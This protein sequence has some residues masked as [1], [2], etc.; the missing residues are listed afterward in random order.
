M[1]SSGRQDGRGRARGGREAQQVPD[2]DF[3]SYYGRP[4]VRETVWGP[5]I[6]SYL[7]LG[8]LAGASSGLAAAAHLTGNRELALAAKAAAAG[9]ISLSMAALVHDLGR[10]ARFINML[11]VLKVTSP[12]SVGTWIVSGYAPLAFAAAACN[13]TQR[14]RTAGTLA[15]IG[16]AALG[17][18]VASYTAVLLSDT[19]TPAWHGAYRELPYLFAGSAASAA[20]GLGMLAVRPD[21]ARQ[22][23]RL[24]AVG[25]TA[26][27]AARHLLERR[28]GKNA[29]PYRTGRAGILLKAA[30]G[31]TVAG[32]AGTVLAGTVLAGQRR[33]AAACSGAALLVA[34]ALTRFGVFEAGRASARDPK[35]TVG[36]QRDGL[37]MRPVGDPA[38]SDVQ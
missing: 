12:M 26:E 36:P 1:A 4:V 21:R 20:G 32:L 29:E 23:I 3:S 22:A 11:R 15:T 14:L 33:A 31:L 34:S 30:E 8:G 17:P 38:A 24:A 5:D 6:P 9:A 27:L 16:A 25:A 13:I 2:A 19:A 28:L 18:A 37:R 10:P 7:F 35:Y